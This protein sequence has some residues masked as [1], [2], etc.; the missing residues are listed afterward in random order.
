[1]DLRTRMREILLLGLSL[2]KNY[3]SSLKARTEERHPAGEIRFRRKPG[4]TRKL[5]SHMILMIILWAARR[6][7]N[8]DKT[9]FVIDGIRN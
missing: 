9:V 3:A 4:G 8:L 1:M 6:R 5:G 7:L 2:A